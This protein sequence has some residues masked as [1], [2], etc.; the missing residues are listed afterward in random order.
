MS[1]KKIFFLVGEEEYHSEQT[2][3]GF[4]DVVCKELGYEPILDLGKE[5]D[6]MD[7]SGLSEADLL[8]MFVRFREPTEEQLS[9][10]HEWFATGRPAVGIRTTSHAFTNARGWC[11]DYFGGHYMSH[12]PNKDG[13]VAMVNPELSDHPIVKDLPAS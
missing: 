7:L 9:L 4:I 10:L 6:P 2:M 13:T 1:S 12:A 5:Q 3:P 8:V 11:P